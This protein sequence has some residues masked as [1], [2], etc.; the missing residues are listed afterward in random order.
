[1]LYIVGGISQ[2]KCSVLLISSDTLV[3]TISVH[4]SYGLL[5]SLWIQVALPVA[6]GIMANWFTNVKYCCRCATDQYCIIQSVLCTV[7][8]DV[9]GWCASSR[10]C[11][12]KWQYM[13]L[14]QDDVNK[15]SDV[16]KLLLYLK[17]PTGV[18]TNQINPSYVYFSSDFISDFKHEF[19]IY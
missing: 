9:C 2:E 8:N 11:T 6:V 12:F 14:F 13:F 17:L 1:M 3:L 5:G 10:H 4:C 19:T 16:E 15:L 18:T 7:L